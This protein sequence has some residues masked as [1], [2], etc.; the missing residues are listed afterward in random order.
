MSIVG[1]ETQFMSIVGMETQ[2]MSSVGMETQSYQ[3]LAWV[4]NS[5]VESVTFSGGIET[6]LLCSILDY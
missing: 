5:H 2:F 3:A 6:Q 1:M 4:H